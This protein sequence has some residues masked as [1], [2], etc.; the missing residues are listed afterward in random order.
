MRPSIS[1]GEDR[2]MATL[3][4]HNGSGR[5]RS[6][7]SLVRR[8]AKAPHDRHPGCIRPTGLA[9]STDRDY[10]GAILLG[11]SRV[12]VRAGS[13]LCV[14]DAGRGS[15]EILAYGNEGI[16]ASVAESTRRPATL[17]FRARVEHQRAFREL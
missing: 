9:S 2:R 14:I 11:V 13:E 8:N 3:A 10:A 7:G 1:R 16:S 6:A 15:R 4:R 17:F 12:L 5:R